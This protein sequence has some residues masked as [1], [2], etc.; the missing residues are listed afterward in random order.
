MLSSTHLWSCDANN[1]VQGLIRRQQ[2]RQGQGEEGKR[3][4]KGGW[5]GK[6]E[7]KEEQW[8]KGF[9]SFYPII[10]KWSDIALVPF[11]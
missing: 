7:G 2:G 4:G 11:K 10:V 9:S 3:E 8:S 1:R 5:E 6:R